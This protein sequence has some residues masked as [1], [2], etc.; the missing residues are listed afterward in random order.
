VGLGGNTP[1]TLE[2]FARIRDVLKTLLDRVECSSLYHTSAQDDVEQ[3]DF[4]N[5]VIAGEWVGSA[6]GLLERLL[7]LESRQG[8]VRS[9]SRPKGPRLVDLDLL[10]FGGELSAT[11]RLWLPHP[12]LASRRFALE[13]LVELDSQALDPRTGDRWSVIL[14]SLPD[15][16]VDRV[17]RTW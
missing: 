5:A 14:G 15:Q 8:R 13:P 1:G 7:M 16:G 10:C 6:S 9:P 2:A 12:R 17:R 4:W 3:D 11:P